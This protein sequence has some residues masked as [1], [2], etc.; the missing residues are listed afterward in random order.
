MIILNVEDYWDILLGTIFPGFSL[1]SAPPPPPQS[2]KTQ[3]EKK[4]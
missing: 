2:I 4:K 3:K 1:S